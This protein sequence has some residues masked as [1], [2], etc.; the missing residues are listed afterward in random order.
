MIYFYRKHFAAS[1]PGAF[2]MMIYVAVY[3]RMVMMML[4]KTA[5]RWK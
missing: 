5:K 1:Y 2:N 3:A 4:I